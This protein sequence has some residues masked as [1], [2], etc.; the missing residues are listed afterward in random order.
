MS[1]GKTFSRRKLLT[2]LGIAGAALV[3][4]SLV[5][6]TFAEQNVTGS[7]YGNDCDCNADDISY[8]LA[9]G[10]TERTV[11]DR[12]RESVSVKDF[13]ARGDGVTND[14]AAIQAAIDYLNSIGGG[15]LYFPTGVYRATGVQLY[16]FI[17][18]RG[19][20]HNVWGFAN[21]GKGAV[22]KSWSAGKIFFSAGATVENITFDG[23]TL[24]GL[25][26]FGTEDTQGI[27]LHW[28][29]GVIINNCDFFL[30]KHEAFWQQGGGTLRMH[31]CKIFGVSRKGVFPF[32]D[33]RRRATVRLSG[34]DNMITNTEF[35]GDYSGDQVNLPNCAV[36][37]ENAAGNMFANCVFEGADVGVM[38]A[39]PDNNFVN[40]R[41]DI[42]YGHGFW[43][44]REDPENDVPPWRIRLSNC[45][46]HRNGR[47][48]RNL[49]DNFRIESGKY[50][51]DI[52]MTNCRSSNWTQDAWVHRYGLYDGAGDTLV[53]AFRDEGAATKWFD[54][55][56]GYSGPQASFKQQ[57]VASSGTATP[58]VTGLSVLRFNNSEAKTIAGF[59]N[60]VNGQT[61][62]LITANSYTS[63][64]H[65]AA[66]KTNELATKALVPDK[67]YRFKCISGIWY[68]T[69]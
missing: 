37:L 9:A 49:F 4:G 42:N 10:L 33:E 18:L 68:E 3:S 60:G 53:V 34:H 54:G 64:S 46:A 69:N 32:P 45:W 30:F 57:V 11:G 1:G 12:L 31:N 38:I 14:T 50:I 56:A 24:V 52:Q 6:H 65:N 35:G 39:G 51:R 17:T 41:A 22:I 36:K 63:I 25:E 66:I 48:G 20:G 26:S 7:V 47:Y 8:R 23:L 15:S 21:R 29:I 62:D 19:P 27:V 5:T 58:D 2:S 44:T 40:C 61:L 59:L 55:I 43:F 28:S 13:G 16:S 67:L